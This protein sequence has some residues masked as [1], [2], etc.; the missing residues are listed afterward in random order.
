MSEP[1]KCETKGGIKAIIITDEFN[2]SEP[3][4]SIIEKTKPFFQ[5]GDAMAEKGETIMFGSMIYKKF[6][7]AE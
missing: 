3:D 1:F 7:D 6:E 4:Y 5:I 2:F